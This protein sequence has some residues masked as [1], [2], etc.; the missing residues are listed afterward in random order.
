MCEQLV[1]V[2]VVVLLQATLHTLAELRRYSHP[3]YRRLH[4]IPIRY[5]KRA[6]CGR[7]SSTLI[8]T[9]FLKLSYH[10]GYLGKCLFMD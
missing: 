1:F 4:P 2:V 5:T 10:R 9:I 7:I 6:N 8:D 3:P